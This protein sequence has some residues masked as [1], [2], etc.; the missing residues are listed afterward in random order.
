MVQA[1]LKRGG[2]QDLGLLVELVEAA[3][4]LQVDEDEVRA[5]RLSDPPNLWGPGVCFGLLFRRL[6]TKRDISGA[7]MLKLSILRCKLYPSGSPPLFVGSRLGRSGQMQER[8]ERAPGPLEDLGKK[9][10]QK[11]NACPKARNG[12]QN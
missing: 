1:R 4:G 11:Q 5:P 7:G 3:G 2:L 8:I 12:Q 6:E 9:H 10:M